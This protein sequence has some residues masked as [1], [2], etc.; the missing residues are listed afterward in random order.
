M[1]FYYILINDLGLRVPLLVSSLDIV[2]RTGFMLWWTLKPILLLDHM[3]KR[4]KE[5]LINSL[6]SVLY[7][8][9]SVTTYTSQNPGYRIYTVDG[10]YNESSRQVL[11]H[12]TY[13][14]NITDANLTNKPKWI[15]EYTAK[16]RQ[17]LL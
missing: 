9:P 4:R 5:K 3:G 16:V 6:C 1:F 11:D 10:N 8:G 17:S 15:H 14:L 2:T 13:I 7:L 12:D